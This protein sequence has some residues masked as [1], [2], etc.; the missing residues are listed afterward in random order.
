MLDIHYILS[1]IDDSISC[2]FSIQ[3]FK[4]RS[5][6]VSYVNTSKN[7]NVVRFDSKTGNVL[8]Q[9]TNLVLSNNFQSV[10]CFNTKTSGSVVYL[11]TEETHASHASPYLRILDE[12]LNLTK[13]SKLSHTLISMA[14]CED[15]LCVMSSSNP[16][17]NTLTTFDDKLEIVSECGQ[18]MPDSPFYIPKSIVSFLVND[19]YLVLSETV[20]VANEMEGEEAV[21]E[22]DIIRYEKILLVSKESGHVVSQFEMSY[23]DTWRL[24]LDKYILTYHT[25]THVLRSYNLSGDFLHE[26]TFKDELVETTFECIAGKELYFYN[27]DEKKLYHF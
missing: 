9:K 3:P 21:D 14:T 25:D 12:N 18:A 13:K 7:L 1:D 5:F 2:N 26:V 10:S 15:C 6:I 16:E 11:Y 19:S 27:E 23:F 20:L 4:N 17:C 22:E 24:Y 8:A